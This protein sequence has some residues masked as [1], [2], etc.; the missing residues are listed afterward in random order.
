MRLDGKIAIVTG[1]TSGIGAAI[2]VAFAKAGATIVAVGRDRARADAVLGRIGD[3]K[4][5]VL[6][7]DVSERGFCDR[8]VAET[9]ARHGA[10]DILVNAAGVIV[11]K[12]AA[13]TTDEDW[14]WTMSTNVHAVF[15]LSRAALA[16]MRPRRSGVIIN[17][18]SDAAVVGA[19]LSAA[20]CASKG[21]VLQ[22]SR[23]MALDHAKEGIRVNALCPT[24]VDTPM[25]DKEARDLARD[26]VEF[27]REIADGNPMGRMA[28][29]DEVAD[30]ALFLASDRS[31]FVT[32]A[33]MLLD[34]GFTAG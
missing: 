9:V 27:R 22:L 7:G 3:G 29:A 32:G 14:R 28:T 26:P 12:D 31:R 10:L 2:A 4:A 23:A 34:G 17:I 13:A 11:C 15:Y 21:A 33:T 19:P 5:S 24:W 20:Y 8:A 18:A 1:A 25:I 30:M 6:L 16:A